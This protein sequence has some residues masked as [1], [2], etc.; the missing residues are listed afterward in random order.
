MELTQAK[1]PAFILYIDQGEE[2]YVRA[3]LRQRRRFSEILVQ[4]LRD[5]RLRALMSIRS[6]F[7]G[8][9]QGD[10]PLFDVRRQIDVPPLREAQLREVVSRPAELLSA[11]FETD[12]LAADI[13]R[14]TAEESAKDAGAL[15]LLSYLLDDMWTQMVK[16][17]D[18]MLRLPPAAMEIGG[19]LVERANSFLSHHPQSEDAL[20]RLLTLR[21]ATVREDGEPTRRRAA[22]SEFTADEWRLVSEL[23]DHPNRLLVTATPE[24]GESYAE[25]AHEAIFRRWQ[26]LREWIAGQKDFLIWKSVL[27]SDRRAWEAAPANA[28]SGA[29]LMG[30]KL[31]QAQSRLAERAEDLATVDRQFIAASVAADR[32]AAR[33]RQRLQGAIGV[34]MLGTI[35]LLL[36]VIFKDEIG[37]LWFEQTTLRRYIAANV[38]PYVRTPKAERALKPETRS[39]NA[40]KTAPRCSSFR[41]ASSG[42]DRATARAVPANIPAT[43]SGSTGRSPSAS[44]RSPGTIGKPASTRGAAMA[45][46]LATPTSERG[47]GR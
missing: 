14:R 45:G 37:D 9:L 29:L 19:V 22:R 6:D 39:G 40:R 31:T 25:V 12:R 32:A 17:G 3:E 30:F 2:L 34:L 43:K 7:M 13:A 18:G 44:S 42:W 15:P 23:A 36:G 10:E 27:E 4:G 41:R 35:A 1:P 38:T 33:N 8:A 26:K 21:L 11:C 16:S 47:A 28:K 5:P 46:R 24:N 20:R